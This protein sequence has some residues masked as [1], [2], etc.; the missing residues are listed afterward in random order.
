MKPTEFIKFLE[1][2]Q[3]PFSYDESSNRVIVKQSLVEGSDRMDKFLLKSL[4]ENLII[5]GHL[6]L[7]RSINLQDLGSDLLVWGSVFLNGCSGLKSLPPKMIVQKSL[8]IS[9]CENIRELPRGLIVGGRL[10]LDGC[11]LYTFDPKALNVGEGILGEYEIIHNSK[12]F[13]CED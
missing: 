10:N 1:R 4:P 12:R 6:D 8:N 3:I 5:W 9:G 11:K 2:Y 7:P 13:I